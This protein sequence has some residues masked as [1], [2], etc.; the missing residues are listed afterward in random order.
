[1]KIP[2]MLQKIIGDF[3]KIPFK[4]YL[5]NTFHHTR[6]PNTEFKIVSVLKERETITKTLNSFWDFGK[7][8]IEID[9]IS[10]VA[11]IVG[12]GGERPGHLKALTHP[13]SGS[14]GDSPQMVAKFHFLKRSKVLENESFFQK[15]Q[16]FS[17]PKNQ[18]FSMKKFEKV[19]I[20]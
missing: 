9:L 11:R 14:E 1:M 12:R 6:K 8:S 13:P 10:G 18:F 2:E 4:K 7:I 15:Y 17:C 3:W 5:T 16:R 19:N 20:F